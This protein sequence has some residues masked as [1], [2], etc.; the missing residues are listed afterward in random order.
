MSVSQAVNDSGKKKIYVRFEDGKKS[1][2]IMHP[3]YSL[4][5]NDGFTDKE[6]SMLINYC[7]EN[8]TQIQELAKTVSIWK[9]F[10]GNKT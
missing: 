1:C 5:S 7:K 4:I 6:I 9:A 10:A 8:P 2:E 3:D